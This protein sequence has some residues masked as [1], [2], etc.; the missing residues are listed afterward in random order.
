MVSRL[1]RAAT[2]IDVDWTEIDEVPETFPPE[3]HTHDWATD[4]TGIQE[5]FPPEPHT[6][7][8]DQI[9]DE[10]DFAPAIHSHSGY[11]PDSH[12][13]SGYAPD[14]HSHSWGQ[15]TSKPD[16]FPPISHTHPMNQITGEIV[17]NYD[18]PAGNRPRLL[19][20]NVGTDTN[21]PND[22]AGWSV[23]EIPWADPSFSYKWQMGA[24]YND[25]IPGLFWRQ[26][27]NL[28]NQPW[29]RIW[30]ERNLPNPLVESL[31][32]WTPALGSDNNIT[33]NYTYRTA[34]YIK[35][36]SIAFI[37]CSLQA[38]PAVG[39]PMPTGSIR[40]TGFPLVPTYTATAIPV[41]AQAGSTVKHGQRVNI[42]SNQLITFQK[43]QVSG[44]DLNI[45]SLL[46]SDSN[47]GS[48]NCEFNLAVRI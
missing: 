1:I 46:W 34:N 14:S 17:S 28:A 25:V 36:N 38:S 20:A 32:S 19:W 10:P 7:P 12:S 11:A 39:Q 13:H 8:W 4:I 15:I 16:N 2:D 42:F 44:T 6:H 23:L 40:I 9:T 33:W 45:A 21:S 5:E 31:A 30:D 24:I 26:T 48:M 47:N 43:F 37:Y 35:H 29:Y 41:S 18:P 3:T 22:G 27:K